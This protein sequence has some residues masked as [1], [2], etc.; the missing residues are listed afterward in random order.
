MHKFQAEK[1][2]KGISIDIR[3]DTLFHAGR[4][5]EC[6]VAGKADAVVTGDEAMLSLGQ[7][8]RIRLVS[9]SDYLGT[10]EP[11]SS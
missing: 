3:A 2:Q 8:R 9:L 6:A 5:L 1:A 11:G 4:I 10:P 7:F